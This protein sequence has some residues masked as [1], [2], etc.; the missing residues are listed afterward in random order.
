MRALV[1]VA[2]LVMTARPVLPLDHDRHVRISLVWVDCSAFQKTRDGWYASKNTTVSVGLDRRG[3]L[4]LVGGAPVNG[5][6]TNGV[7]LEEVLEEM[8]AKK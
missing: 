6:P 3:S 7:Y 2:L 8:C 4:S 1:I 5:L